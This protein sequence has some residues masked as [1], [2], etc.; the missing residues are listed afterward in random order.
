VS[1]VTAFGSPEDAARIL[2]PKG[3]KLL[4]ISTEVVQLPAKETPLGL[5]EVP[6]KSYYRWQYCMMHL[7]SYTRNFVLSLPCCSLAA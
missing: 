3:A 7:I 6:P 5:L 1:D 4:A 2:V